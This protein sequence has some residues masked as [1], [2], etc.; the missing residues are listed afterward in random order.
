MVT[1]KASLRPEYRALPAP[2]ALTLPAR[3]LP[4]APPAWL[5][6][7]ALWLRQGLESLRNMLGPAELSVFDRAEAA[8]LLYVLAGLVQTGVPDVLQDQPL[9]AEEIAARA[10][11]DADVVFRALCACAAQ[12]FFR[13][14][15][16]GRFV[17][18]ARSRALR[19]GR[20]SRTREVLLYFSSGSNV[21]AW[22]HFEHA[23]RTGTSPF[24]HVHGT[25]VWDWF[26]EHPDERANFADGMLGM[27]L[28]QAPV[29]AKLYPFA[30]LGIVC[31]VGGGRGTL[32]SELLLRYPHLR[33]MLQDSAEVLDSAR[34]VLEARG[35]LSRVEL[36]PG[37]FFEAVPAGA[38][39]Y[40]L[41]NVLHDWDAARCLQILRNVR[42]ASGPATRVLIA[43]NLLEPGADNRLALASDLQMLVA[44]SG[45]RERGVAEL[46]RLLAEA[47]F[48]LRR[49]FR[50][51]TISVLEA[52]TA[53]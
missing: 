24:E 48:E 52:V 7:V 20:L 43:E 8:S 34:A 39:A 45:G 11:L 42:A 18:N 46:G 6:R 44:C 17:H 15:R 10:G 9:G 35:V 40:L 51:P 38:D 4:P 41:K 26:R 49:V 27:S 16:D 12:G 22:T 36:C 32:L 31:D 14:Q 3:A 19:K 2:S 13:R 33:G 1:P 47:G 37:N 53:P 29:I 5:V 50:Y 25:D 23:L 28:A 21:A 30:E